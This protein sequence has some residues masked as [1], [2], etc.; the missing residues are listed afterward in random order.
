MKFTQRVI[1]YKVN[2]D[3]TVTFKV[4]DENNQPQYFRSNARLKLLLELQELK[5]DTELIATVGVYYKKGVG[6]ALQLIE[7]AYE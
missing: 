1:F 3:N 2:D 4:I 6:L 5:Q 7:V